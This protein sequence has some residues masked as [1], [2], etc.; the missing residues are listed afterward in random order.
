MNGDM[1]TAIE[2]GATIVRIGTTIFGKKTY[3]DSYYWNEHK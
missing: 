2:K 1:E 3:P